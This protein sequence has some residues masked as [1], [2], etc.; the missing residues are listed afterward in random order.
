ML[1]IILLLMSRKRSPLKKSKF[2]IK[3][4]K[5]SH[6]T[7]NEEW[8]NGRI[9]TEMKGIYLINLRYSGQ[10]G[11]GVRA[12]TSLQCWAG[13]SGLPISIVEPAMSRTQLIGLISKKN[14]TMRLT[15]YF[16]IKHF[17]TRSRENGYAELITQ[18]RFLNK[19]PNDIIY[20]QT[21][22]KVHK[23]KWSNKNNTEI[24]YKHTRHALLRKLV[25]LGYCIVK[26]VPTKGIQL[27]RQKI[28]EILGEW[29]SKNVT[30]VF[31]KWEGPWVT[32][33]QC[34]DFTII[35][36]FSPSERLLK[37]ANK[38][39]DLYM[40]SNSS[41]AIMM[42]LEHA[43]ILTWRNKSYTIDKCLRNLVQIS[44]KLRGKNNATPVITADIG[45]YGSNSWPQTIRDKEKLALLKTR[46]L[47]TIEVLLNHRMSFERWERSFI[48]AAGG[49]INRGY[50]AA[51]Q[52]VI[53]SRADCLVLMGGGSFQDLALQDYIHFHKDRDKWCIRIIC[54][55][56]EQLLINRTKQDLHKSHQVTT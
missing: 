41:L 20:V 8:E 15:D 11:A 54:A 24:C 36:Q 13:H 17:N 38:Y 55:D 42:R 25:K 53:A 5:T 1:I 35:N 44:A 52:R 49:V 56:N 10:Q 47:N 9:E 46:A 23:T 32:T 48:E 2:K 3:G 12:L 26:I 51:L 19:G 37:D 45:E 33:S 29:H 14:N 30:L 50:I 21:G 6:H 43:V 40:G 18:N 22:S 4:S 16:N 34:K 31:S 28:H 7:E 39:R 27:S